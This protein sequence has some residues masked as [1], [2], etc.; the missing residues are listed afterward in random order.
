MRPL[1]VFVVALLLLIPGAPP[2]AARAPVALAKDGPV[3][4]PYVLDH[5][6]SHVLHPLNPATLRYDPYG[7][8]P[9][10]LPGVHTDLT[11]PMAAGA[12]GAFFAATTFR[13]HNPQGSDYVPDNMTIHVI[14]AAA[15]VQTAHFHPA[16]PILLDGI[17]DDGSQVYGYV[18]DSQTGAIPTWAA[19]SSSDGRVIHAVPVNLPGGVDFHYGPAAGR[20][21]AF[22]PVWGGF[23]SSTPRSP[24]LYSYDVRSGRLLGHLTLNGVTAGSWSTGRQVSD[25]PV[26]D[27]WQ[28]GIALSPDG[29]Q[30][31]VLDGADNRLTLV[32]TGNMRVSRSAVLFRPGS[33]LQRVADWLGILPA[34]ALAKEIE[35]GSVTASFAPDGRS[36]YVTGAAA[37]VDDRGNQV[38]TGRGIERVD[39]STGQVEA[40]SLSGQDPSILWIGDALYALAR[41]MGDATSPS[42]LYRLAPDT[43]AIQASHVFRHSSWPQVYV[44]ASDG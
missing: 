39:A 27:H 7:T 6:T 36:L 41:P 38:W 28:P 30:M 18:I 35:G 13:S 25:G 1:A 23:D 17:T 32:D 8:A 4:Q 44:L 9:I 43:L 26:I 22:V 2:R 14:D 15:G 11:G 5:N 20:L 37:T 3:V 19:L 33:V 34:P 29:R 16:L 12:N 24:S 10:L 42:T 31:A 21:Y 40:Q